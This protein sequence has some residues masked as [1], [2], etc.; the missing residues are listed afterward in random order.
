MFRY[1]I[2][3]LTGKQNSSNAGFT[4]LIYWY[5]IWSR[6]L[7]ISFMSRITETTNEALLGMTTKLKYIN[8]VTQTENVQYSLNI[9]TNN[10]ANTWGQSIF[11]KR[12]K[13]Q[14]Y[15]HIWKIRWPLSRRPW[16]YVFVKVKKTSSVL[17][18]GSANLLSFLTT[19]H[20]LV[21]LIVYILP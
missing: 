13:L 10:F 14:M 1:K 11:D 6:S 3:T 7:P 9:S 19:H 5:K 18:K 21:L 12:H 20:E 16:P 8:E 4:K 2:P 17:I 15:D